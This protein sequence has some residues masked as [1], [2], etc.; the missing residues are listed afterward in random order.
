MKTKNKVYGLFLTIKNFGSHMNSKK[1]FFLIFI[2]AGLFFSVQNKIKAQSPPAPVAV[3]ATDI[4]SYSFVANW[5]EATGAEGYFVDVATD[6]GF[7]S[8]ISGY[9]HVYVGNLLSVQVVGLTA[10]T[11]YFYRVQANNSFGISGPSNIIS[12]TTSLPSTTARPA[13]DITRKSFTAHW[14]TLAIS[15]TYY[16]DVATDN[17]FTNYVNGF[18]NRN[19]GNV[20]KYQLD[21]IL[22]SNTNYYYRVR[23]ANVNSISSNSNTISVT[24]LASAPTTPV[25][26][27]A[28]AVQP[29]VVL[30]TWSNN[31][32]YETGF[33]IERKL[34]S[35]SDFTLLGQA[36][37][38][39]T[40]YLD[41][42]VEENRQYDY[43]IK[44]FN[45]SL[46]SDYSNIATVTSAFSDVNPPSNLIAKAPSIGKVVLTWNDNSSNEVAFSIERKISTQTDFIFLDRVQANYT[47]YQDNTVA[48]K[49]TY[50]YRVIAF[51]GNTQSTYSNVA[52]IT[53]LFSS[54]N[55]PTQLTAASPAVGWVVLSWT[56]NTKDELG[57]KV[58]RKLFSESN[59][60]LIDSVVQ[61]AT[62]YW[63]AKTNSGKIYNYRVK[64]YNLNNE[65]DYS[66]IVTVTSLTS[67]DDNKIIPVN[68]SLAQNFPNPFNPETVIG[69]QLPASGYVSL[70][71][72]DLLGREVSTLV[73]EEKAAGSYEVKFDAKNLPSGIYF[74]TIQAGEF[75]QVRKMLLLK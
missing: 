65:S 10:S 13:T 62:S 42:T 3:A 54:L 55:A 66:N 50:N 32:N 20:I 36:P 58:E 35:Q 39:A 21:T 8:I 48:Q 22:T 7:A 59:F 40:S 45:T 41:L 75:N 61:D 69:Y 17:L 44:G 47:T 4:A 72:Y 19:V 71:V 56:D 38:A 60:T 2:T 49:T 74:Y 11:T 53:T 70:K 37:A 27:N 51:N 46:E 43:R 14:D 9:N 18:T 68:Y 24:T 15:I 6:A 16:L 57:F 33:K 28:S 52:T 1:I 64:A 34:S 30:L 67:I 31:S 25:N 12:L 29:G 5:S 73:N 23:T 63:D 26:L